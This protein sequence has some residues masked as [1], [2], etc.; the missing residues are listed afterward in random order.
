MKPG[1]GIEEEFL[2]VDLKTRRV[3]ATPSSAVLAAC[4]D[5]F[6]AHFSQEMFKSQ[7]EL[8][9]PVFDTLAQAR[10][11]LRS[12]RQRLAHELAGQGMG[13]CAA[14]SHPCGAWRAQQPGAGEHFRQLFDDHRQVARRSLVCGLHIHVGIAPAHD[15][16]R[17][18]NLLVP[19]L[20]LLL[21][22]STS[23]PF[24]EGAHTGYRSY[25]RVLCNEW[26]RMGLPERLHDWADYQRYVA[27]LR[28]TG[29]LR[30]HFDCWWVIR[31]SQRYP[32]LELR[33]ADGCPQ[34]EDGLCI[35]ALFR[36]MVNHCLETGEVNTRLSRE[37]L[38][39]TQENL[40][41]AMRYGR[42][43]D[44]I[45]PLSQQP[46]SAQAWLLRLQD[47]FAIDNEQIDHAS[48][49]LTHG[50]SADRQLAIYARSLAQG[51]NHTRALR[52]VVDA[53]VQ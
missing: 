23:S 29:S 43:G 30:A 21:L 38:W 26:P 49:M 3:V 12:H 34:L 32:T 40:W 45:D 6:G 1:F 20:P 13:I 7:I 9:S 51:F 42:E 17:V 44:F 37:M 48:H 14:G 53:L 52:D 46:L 28:R 19:W 15:R 5:I 27:L 33:I 39:V 24:W 41:R 10:D 2:L 47:R 36:H 18:M 16:I 8:V 31:P 50:T 22:L 11:F 25:R 35:A 4:K